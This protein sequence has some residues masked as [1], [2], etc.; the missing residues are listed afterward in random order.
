MG[1]PANPLPPTEP[2]PDLRDL[3]AHYGSYGRAMGLLVRE[4]ESLKNVRTTVCRKRR[5]LLHGCR[6]PRHLEPDALYLRLCRESR[7]G[8]GG[9]PN[10]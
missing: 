10:R 4:G 1:L 3:E 5:A 7:A 2:P 8:G 6:R 9:P